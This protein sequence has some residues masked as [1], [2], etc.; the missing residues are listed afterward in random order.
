MPSAV[1]FSPVST[2]KPSRLSS[3]AMLRVS[4]IGSFNGASAS[5]YFALPITSA[6]R[7][8]ASAG[9]G[10]T[11]ASA[12]T[13][14]ASNERRIVI[15][16]PSSQFS[17]SV[18]VLRACPRA[19]ARPTL[20]HENRIIKPRAGYQPA[21]RRAQ[22]P[23]W[24]PAHVPAKVPAPRPSRKAPRMSLLRHRRWP[25][26]SYGRHD[27][28]GGLT[29]RRGSGLLGLAP[30]FRSSC[31][32][33]APT[34]TNFGKSW[35]LANLLILVPLYRSEVPDRIRRLWCRD[36]R[37]AVLAQPKKEAE[38]METT[39]EIYALRYATMSPRTPNMNFLTPDPHETAAS[40]LDYFVWLVRGGGR[41]ILVDTG[42]NAEEAAVRNRKLTLNP[43]QA[44]TP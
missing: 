37:S 1:R 38:P 11:G 17:A 8:A 5:G 4:L 18:Q 41:N 35:A 2:V 26:F 33:A 36:F 31:S 42:F 14:T 15:L 13:K 30:I 19:S 27:G 40:D 32:I 3:S 23:T 28:F 16:L 12:N 24:T 10:T 43:A 6:N 21:N 20:S 44:P 22:P 25:S 39:Y 29:F 9:D 34:F 7:S